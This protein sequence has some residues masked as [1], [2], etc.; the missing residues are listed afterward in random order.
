MKTNMPGYRSLP[1]IF[2][3]ILVL[4]GF[5]LGNWQVTAREQ[6]MAG[7]S[8]RPI[9]AN[10]VIGSL[11]FALLCALL[12]ISLFNHR[13]TQGGSITLLVLGVLVCLIPIALTSFSA[14]PSAKS[15]SVYLPLSG[16]FVA[17]AGLTGIILHEYWKAEQ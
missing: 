13:M 4:V 16:A 3:L 17:V 1:Y 12:F 11:L 5:V 2:S 14:N 7:E 10:A 8:L 15:V 6:I 9:V